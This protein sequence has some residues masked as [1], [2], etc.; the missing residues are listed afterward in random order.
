MTL[1]KRAAAAIIIVFLSLAMSLCFFAGVFN[2]LEYKTYDL[3]VNL[4]AESARPSDDIVLVLLDQSS[5]DW[6]NET[7]NWG[8]PW[9]R[10][11]YAEFVDYMNA[12]GAKSAAFDVL[13]SEPSLYRNADQDTILDRAASSLRQAQTL[14]E[15]T[16]GQ[17]RQAARGAGVFFMEALNSLRE[18]S[19]HE[20]D[21][22]FER[23]E[24]DFGRVV[25][26]VFFSTQTGNAETWPSDLDKPLFTLNNFDAIADNFNLLNEQGDVKAQFP[27]PALRNAAGVIGNVTGVP[28]SDSIFRRMRL[29]T[30]FDNKAVP[31]LSAASLLVSD[32]GG[33]I[34]FDEKRRII[35]WDEYTIPVDKEGKTILRFRGPLDY[36]IHY[37]ASDVLRSAEAYKK[38]DDP[39]LQSED[40]LPPEN[41][42]DAY[43][44]FGFYAPGLF[45]ICSSP[46]SSVYPGI[47]MHLTMLDNMLQGDFIRESPEFVNIISIILAITLVVLLVF[48][49][50]NI[51]TLVLGT[52]LTLAALAG[53]G[54]G[55]YRFAGIWLPMAA[56]LFAAVIAFLF[57]AVYNYATEGS[58]K[59]FI[60]H[61]FS[62]YLSPEVIKLIIADP[63]KLN[64]GGERREMTAIFT[65]IQRFSSIS[66]ELQEQ[67]GEDGPRVLVNLLNLYLT[68]MSDIV[69]A[70][71]GTIDKY[72]GDAIIAFFGAPLT[73]PDHASLAC[74]TA[75]QM[76]KRELELRDEIMKSDGF[77]YAVLNKLIAA[78]VIRKERPLYTRIGV[79][80]GDMVVGNMGTPGKMDYTVMGNAVNL[81]ARLEGV[82]KQYDTHGILISEYTRRHIGDEFVLRPLSRVTV[83]GIP[84]PLRL[85]ELLDTREDAPQ[86]LLEMTGLWQEAVA[87]YEE[88]D[89][90]AALKLFGIVTAADDAD[91]TAKLYRKRCEGY[92]R[93]PPPESWNGVDN[94]TEK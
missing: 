57:T 12:G 31:G 32:S 1:S 6:A 82:N 39:F 62:R 15:E 3:R 45:D 13:F 50:N 65:D 38:G 79:N 18:L 93:E 22:A 7:R 20:D 14:I 37:S 52:I 61:A 74:R 36:Y 91:L 27:I 33:E 2:Y 58:Q 11:A 42:K 5:I 49:A 47:G 40:Y 78:N 25:Q 28:D 35:T 51:P 84:A 23:A 86:S 87:R 54:L 8:W 30:L 53:L 43:V 89:F 60:Q 71:K 88:R 55:A 48:Y 64:L 21:A 26:T 59:R 72:E 80:S 75:I 41:F 73:E 34:S 83:V 67:Y 81:A 69:L 94:L 10:K 77:F 16:Q 46:I 56:P 92:I 66:S 63:S 19:A 4:F 68:E 76:K 29:F 44:F 9:P 24:R 85:Y 70:N 90:A 17:G